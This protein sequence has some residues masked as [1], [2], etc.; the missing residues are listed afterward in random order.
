MKS[1]LR[2]TMPLLKNG[3]T[4]PFL[5]WSM[6]YCT[7]LA[8]PFCVFLVTQAYH[9]TAFTEEGLDLI[10]RLALFSAVVSFGALGAGIS[11]ISRARNGEDV[12]AGITLGELVAVQTVGAVFALVLSLMFMGQLIAGSM[13]PNWEP[14]YNIIY[15]PA[16]FAKLLV[17]SFIAGFFERFVPNMLRNLAQR[18]QDDDDRPLASRSGDAP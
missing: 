10:V 13:F 5:V 11:L 9:A 4:A 16:A 15:S 17:W 7:V 8:L 14:F 18:A 12:P 6:L 3:N 1:P 2:M